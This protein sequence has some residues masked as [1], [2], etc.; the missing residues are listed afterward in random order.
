MARNIDISQLSG[1]SVQEDN[2]SKGSS[3]ILK[4]CDVPFFSNKKFD[5][6][7]TESNGEKR[8]K[9][10]LGIDFMLYTITKPGHSKADYSKERNYWY[11]RKFATHY[12]DRKTVLCPSTFGK[13]C[14]ICEKVE[15]LKNEYNWYT[16]GVQ[17]NLDP[18]L[19]KY[20]NQLSAREKYIYPIRYNKELYL[21][22]MSTGN[23]QKE[24][25]VGIKDAPLNIQDKFFDDIKGSTAIIKFAS[26]TFGKNPFWKATDVEFEEGREAISD[27]MANKID[28]IDIDSLFIET[29]D[30]ELERLANTIKSG[31][32]EMEDDA[33]VDEENE[34]A[35]E[36]RARRRATVAHVESSP[37]EGAT[38]WE[39][40]PVSDSDF[41]E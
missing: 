1:K 12:V 9:V 10:K 38:P 23:L 18:S 15:A 2:N 20:I 3:K 39:D 4:S 33:D 25:M 5:E 29:D 6:I 22:E 27:E 19:K 7:A 14:P 26:D 16:K 35:V 37:E 41:D 17:A 34:S 8:E 28:A 13:H 24:L 11:N 31:G 32:Q 36:S 21:M 30:A 40:T